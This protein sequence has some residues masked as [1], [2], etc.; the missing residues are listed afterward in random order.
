MKRFVLPLAFLCAV[1]AGGPVLAAEPLDPEDPVAKTL[2]FMREEEKL[3]HDLYLLF[4]TSHSAEQPGANVFARITEAEQRHMDAVLTLLNTYGVADPVQQAVLEDGTL[5][6]NPPG[7]FT[8]PTLQALYDQ[9]VV[10]GGDSFAAA[11]GVGIAVEQTDSAALADGIVAS[12]AY[13]DIVQ[14]YSSLLVAS[15]RHLAAFTK[16]L[17]RVDPDIDLDVAEVPA[18]TPGL[19]KKLGQGR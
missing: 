19:G 9:Y 15:Q 3:A 11:L 8:D 2:Q 14:V 10:Q 1:V 5:V 16:V 12:S 17:D 6:F 13:A 7:V 18:C 4:S